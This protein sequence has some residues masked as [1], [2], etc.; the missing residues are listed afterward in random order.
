[1]FAFTVVCSTAW[2]GLRLIDVSRGTP[3]A[4]L[5]GSTLVIV[6]GVLSASMIST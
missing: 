3:V 6:R 5:A 2:L 4:L 1:M